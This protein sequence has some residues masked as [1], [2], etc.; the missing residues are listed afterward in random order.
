MR[1]L[2]F[3]LSLLIHLNVNANVRIVCGPDTEPCHAPPGVWPWIVTFVR[4]G[5]TAEQ[6]AFCGG[7]LI[8]PSWVL[9][10]THCVRGEDMDSLEIIIGRTTLSEETGDRIKIAEIIQHPD[11]DYSNRDLP[12]TS[13]IALVRLATPSTYPTIKLADPHIDS[14]EEVGILTTVMGWG[15]TKYSGGTYSDTLRFVEL[16]IVSNATC[17]EA[18]PGG[19]RETMICAGYKEGGKDA[20]EG[21]SGGPLVVQENDQWYQIGIVSF[22]EECALPDYYGVYTRVS[23]F[24][25]FVTQHAC[26]PDD[27]PSPPHLEIVID[28]RHATAVW[29]STTKMDGYRFYYAPYSNPVSEV[30]LDNIHSFD[31][32]KATEFSAD[33]S[34]GDAYYVAVRAYRGNCTSEY[35]NIGTV[36]IP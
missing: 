32:D 1:I 24:Q 13:D 10:A 18:F 15:K 23:A 5:E 28:Q 25:D 33:L 36:I 6:S 7:S 3:L 19:I 26:Q 31:M 4:T 29:Y 35:S 14:L 22:G 2:T 34:S 9:T 8:H 30:T 21:D 20:C 12:P 11:Y 27:I 17:E 16:P